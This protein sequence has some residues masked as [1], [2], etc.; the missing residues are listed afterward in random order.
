MSNTDFFDDDLG[1]Q[2]DA[3]RRIKLG[4][5]GEPSEVVGEISSA[6][7]VPVRPVSDFNLTRM[8]KHKHEVNEQV[9]SAM[10]ELERLRKRQEDLEREKKDLEDLRRKQEEFERGKREMIERLNQSLISLEKD[11]I[12]SQRLSELLGETR[13]RFKA[14]QADIDKVSEENWPENQIREELNKAVVILED[15]RLEYNKS[16][17]RIEAVSND[18]KKVTTESRPV[19][20][21]ESGLHREV[22]KPFAFWVKV[23][24]AVS[25]PLVLTIV[26]IFVLFLVLHFR[27]LM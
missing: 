10:Q 20:F 21:E 9:A 26:I 4:G 25:T 2:R 1:K 24:M 19:I 15:A 14:M 16:M 13:K 8:A 23:G 7:D 6:D 22:E 17:T 5:G 12:E 18:S 27:G 11:E 3:A